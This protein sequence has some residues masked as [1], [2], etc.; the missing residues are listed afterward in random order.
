MALP[1]GLVSTYSRYK[2]DTDS[3]ASWLASKAKSLGCPENILSSTSTPTVVA[4]RGSRLKGKERVAAKKK[5]ASTS[6]ADKQPSSLG[7]K[8]II[9]IRDFISL[10]EYIA[11]KDTAV[12]HT[13]I[14]T[15]E[16]VIAARSAFGFQL[17]EHG[18]HIDEKSDERHQFFIQGMKW[19]S[20]TF[21]G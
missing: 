2:Q 19:V 1:S 11:G 18:K 8:H 3:V 5:A 13:F 16:R 4:T 15:I 7:P 17:Q 14:V 20:E 21:M 10:A 12:P 9:R 6:A